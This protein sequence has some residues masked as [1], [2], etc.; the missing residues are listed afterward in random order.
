MTSIDKKRPYDRT[1]HVLIVD[2]DDT[3]LKFF[4]IHLNKFFS[5]VV[6]VENAKQAL[7]NLKDKE[8]DLVLTDVRM[9]KVD[10]LQLMHK[11]KKAHPDIPVLLIS[12]EPMDE[13]QKKSVDQA[14]G[15]LSK[16][17]SVD[18]LNDF[19]HYGA[20]LRQALKDLTPF[21]LD[22]KKVR[23]AL[24]STEKKLAQYVKAG[25]LKD[26]WA[27][28]QRWQLALKDNKAA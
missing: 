26:A 10:G 4:K 21:L 7:D 13:E 20:D 23:Q 11:I 25:S 3:L 22:A 18:Q 5:K 17:F 15:F 24:V 8:V 2:D 14:D 6:V 16:P 12:G 19:I 27:I 9:P 1:S 28:C